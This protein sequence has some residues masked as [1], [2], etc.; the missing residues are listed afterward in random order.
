[1]AILKDEVGNEVR[2]APSTLVGRSSRCD[3]RLDDPRVS[4][5]HAVIRWH[6]GRWLIRDLGSRN[7]T[8][9]Q[10]QRLQ[11][12]VAVPLEVGADLRFGES[13]AVWW[14]VSV[15]APV[16]MALL[17]SEVVE[18]AGDLLALPSDED[19]KLVV[20]FEDGAWL[21]EAAAGERRVVED[22]ELVQVDGRC[23]TLALPAPQDTTVSAAETSPSVRT[24][25]L[26]LQVSLDEEYVSGEVIDGGQVLSLGSRAHLYLLVTLARARLRDR[27]RGIAEREAGWVYQDELT[28]GLKMSDAHFY[29]AVHRAR[30]QLADLGVRDPQ[31]IVE[32]RRTSRQVRIGARE[33]LVVSAAS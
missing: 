21:A 22:K 27:E 26:R 8:L 33:L 30:R 25:T 17:G 31:R 13:E 24:M 32:R 15:G 7:G 1:M 20:F 9:V 5:E 4:A 29:L 14:V 2:L 16:A 12:G 6:G 28:Q 11:G 23:Y 3:L 19:P 18:G 10:G